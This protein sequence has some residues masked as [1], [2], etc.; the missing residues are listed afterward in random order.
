MIALVRHKEAHQPS[1]WLI[2]RVW[3]GRNGIA[4]WCGNKF[5]FVGPGTSEWQLNLECQGVLFSDLEAA[6]RF[7]K[8]EGWV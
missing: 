2:A 7:A 5:G 1:G 8:S 3:E 6:E 4:F